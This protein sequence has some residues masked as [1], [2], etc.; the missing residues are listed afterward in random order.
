[1]AYSPLGR[2][3]LA[4][5]VRKASDL[6]ETDLRRTHPRFEGENLRRNLELVEHLQKLAD[7]RRCTTAQLALAWVLAQSSIVLPIFSTRRREHLA[8]NVGALDI[9]LRQADL[10]LIG[11]A[12]SPDL[13]QGAR[14][15]AEHMKT[16]E[17]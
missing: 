2:G 12:V 15:P 14:H 16:I 4:G 8:T 1:M 17:S 5:S 11:A 10:D 3:F 13:V 7:E 9:H 6:A